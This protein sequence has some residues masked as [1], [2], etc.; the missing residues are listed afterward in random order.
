MSDSPFF[1]D[2]ANLSPN[3]FEKAYQEIKQRITFNASPTEN[4]TAIVLGGLP[5]AGKGNIYGIAKKRFNG[6]IAEIDCDKFR[7]YH[8]NITAIVDRIAENEKQTAK[9]KLLWLLKQIRSY[10]QLQTD[11]LKN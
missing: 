4:P 10:S 8:P 2:L 6:N 9:K 7:K 5:G 11:L 3:E 1:S